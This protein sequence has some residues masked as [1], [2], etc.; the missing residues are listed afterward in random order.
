MQR[1]LD[2]HFSFVPALM[3]GDHL[4]A[5]DDDDAINLGLDQHLVMAVLD[6]HRV[7]VGLVAHREMEPTR[8]FVVSQ[9]S[10]RDGR[11]GKNTPRSRSNRSPMVSLCP[12]RRC[13]GCSFPLDLFVWSF[14]ACET[15]NLKHEVATRIAQQVLHLTLIVAPV[16]R[17]DLSENG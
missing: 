10:K 6:R 12:C 7:A 2:G 1:I 3:L 15:R 9:A 11:G 8:T 16:F 17:S 5:G 4:G 13:T 14:P